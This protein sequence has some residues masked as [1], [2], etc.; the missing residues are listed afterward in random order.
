MTKR[1]MEGVCKV[2][3]AAALEYQNKPQ[4][5]FLFFKVVTQKYDCYVNQAHVIRGNDVLMKCDI[6]SFVT[7][8]VSIL[9]WQDNEEN[10]FSTDSFLSQGM[11]ST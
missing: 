3:Y 9:N 6:P 10:I 1:G 2:L 8:F 4:S 5:L 11:I 7:D